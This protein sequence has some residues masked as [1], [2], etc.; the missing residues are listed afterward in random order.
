MDSPHRKRCQSF[1]HYSH[2]ERTN[3][4]SE[5]IFQSYAEKP[6][7]LLIRQDRHTN[8]R[9]TTMIK[10]RRHEVAALLTSVSPTKEKPGE[11]PEVRATRRRKPAVDPRRPRLTACRQIPGIAGSRGETAIADAEQHCVKAGGHVAGLND[12]RYRRDAANGNLRLCPI[13]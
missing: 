2:K 10:D 4:Q 11:A 9:Q 12:S 6:A 5:E 7:V 1:V 13:F 8:R 3:I